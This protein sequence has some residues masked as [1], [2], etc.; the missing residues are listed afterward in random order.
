MENTEQIKQPVVQIT[1]SGI[2]PKASPKDV[3]LHLFAMGTFYFSVV[4]FL[5]L[6]FEYVNRAFPD[7]VN[8]YEY[9]NTYSDSTIRFALSSLIVIFPVYILTTWYINKMYAKFPEKRDIRIRKWLV[10]LTLFIAAGT[11]IGDLVTLIN[12]F[13]S[14]EITTRFILK[15]IA[16]LFVAGASFGYYLWDLK[17]HNAED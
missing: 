2:H 17:R 1:K 4:N 15:V 13:L 12:T 6:I 16:V 10:Y 14:G 5:L 7:A 9:I 11:V 8:A 3:F